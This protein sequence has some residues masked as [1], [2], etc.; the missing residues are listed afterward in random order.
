M[1]LEI[2]WRRLSSATYFDMIISQPIYVAVLLYKSSIL[3]I[4]FSHLLFHFY[5]HVVIY[6]SQ[7]TERLATMTTSIVKCDETRAV[8]YPV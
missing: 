6:I 8:L 2:F 3:K 4:I 1:L 7:S 5:F